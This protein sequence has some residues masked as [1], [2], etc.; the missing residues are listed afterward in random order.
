MAD[1]DRGNIVVPLNETDAVDG[2]PWELLATG[3]GVLVSWEPATRSAG[4]LAW[5]PA[6]SGSGEFARGMGRLLSTAGV[7]RLLNQSK[8]LFHVELPT[9][10]TLQDLVPAV[11]GGYRG[12]TRGANKA[13]TGQ[14]RLVQ[15]G[16]VAGAAG[17]LIATGPM[18]AMI[19]LAVGAEMLASYQQDRKLRAIQGGIDALRQRGHDDDSAVLESARRALAAGS[20][21]VLD[22]AA[23]PQSLGLG[24][25]TEQVRRLAIREGI[26]LDRV[27]AQLDD[28]AGKDPKSIDYGKMRKV[29]AGGSDG[30][31]DYM[32][33]GDRIGRLYQA[34]SLD[35]RAQ[36][37]TGAEAVLTNPSRTMEHL[38]RQLRLSLETNSQRQAEVTNLLWDLIERPIGF[39]FPNLPNTGKDVANLSRSLTALARA[40]AT[41]PAAPGILNGAQRQV[42]ELVSTG[43][44]DLE[45]QPAVVP[46]AAS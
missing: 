14:V 43:T 26:W 7:P 11:G 8:T 34:V 41:L 24:S 27:R 21:A 28:A 35:S 10:A 13:I 4:G 31:H 20:A 2:D 37:L 16:S 15:A 5:G 18:I 40:S 33:F 3:R 38:Q 30:D 39:S 1:G 17:G 23:I 46:A 42:L 45:V 44:G 12:L 22:Q 25:S 9:G 6:L 19:G 36:V 29:L 32:L